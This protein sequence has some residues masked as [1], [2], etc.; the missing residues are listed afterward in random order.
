MRER[1][2]TCDEQWRQP[3]KFGSEFQTPSSLAA[4]EED[5]LVKPGRDLTSVKTAATSI[6]KLLTAVRIFV[7][8]THKAICDSTA[9]LANSPTDEIIGM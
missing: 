6:A 5:T 7:R 2:T 8:D 1:V 4:R 9:I 3:S